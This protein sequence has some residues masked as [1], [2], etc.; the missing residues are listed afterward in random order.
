MN[1]LH[2]F[3]IFC[4]LKRVVNSV[5]SKADIINDQLIEEV[6][7]MF[8]HSFTNYW[9]M[10]FPHDELKSISGTWTDTLPELGNGVKASGYLGVA[11]TLIDS[12]DTLAVFGWRSHFRKAVRWLAKNIDFDIDVKVHLFETN[13]RLLGGLLSGHL[14]AQDSKLN[15]MPMYAGELLTL[16]ED[17]GDRMMPAFATSNNIPYAWVNLRYGISRLEKKDRQTCLAGVGSLILEFGALSYY[18]KNP[19]YFEA[20][21]LALL[22]L[23]KLRSK[24]DLL[25]NHLDGE[26]RKWVNSNAGIGAGAD[27]YYEYVLKAYITFGNKVHWNM[28]SRLYR[29]VIKHLRTEGGFFVEANMKNGNVRSTQFN[30]LQAYWPG[31]QVLHGDI[32]QATETQEAFFQLWTKFDGLPERVLINTGKA[33]GTQRHYSLRPELI[34]S[35]YHLY[36]ATKDQKFKDM[37]VTM[38]RTIQNRTRA[39]YGYAMMQNVITG[40]LAD[41]M[42]SYFLAETVKYFLLLFDNNHW[43]H[44]RISWVLSTEAHFLPIL[45]SS[46][47][48]YSPPLEIIKHPLDISKEQPTCQNWRTNEANSLI[49]NPFVPG[50]TSMVESVNHEVVWA[51]SDGRMVN[52]SV[53]PGGFTVKFQVSAESLTIRNLGRDTV[54]ILN[55]I[56]D[57][58]I[59]VA[60]V[61]KRRKL[62]LSNWVEYRGIQRNLQNET[63]DDLEDHGCSIN[64]ARRY[65]SSGAFFFE[66]TTLL[67]ELQQG[68]QVQRTMAAASLVWGGFG[69]KPEEIPHNAV[70]QIILIRRGYCTFTKKSRLAEEAGALGLIVATSNEEIFMMSD[71][72]SKRQSKIPVVMIGH[73]SFKDLRACMDVERN[74]W[75]IKV[76]IIE[77]LMSEQ[78]DDNLD[79]SEE[80][81]LDFSGTIDKIRISTLGNGFFTVTND[82]GSFILSSP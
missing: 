65:I 6:H 70:G 36:R 41:Y 23:W 74:L 51:L 32:E 49:A 77:T 14:L 37:G 50:N 34:E 31:L 35:A 52:I 39:Q 20:A 56:G 54:E 57:Q 7:E 40:E 18:T 76:A 13:I 29:A 45:Q 16:A 46:N 80:G 22:E 60:Y 53:I 42:P 55:R 81:V 47:Y 10:A 38:L 63:V 1:L 72:G 8:N 5:Q 75:H 11:L 73:E 62:F 30:A 33:H 82:N 67:R 69:C 19:V 24:L 17:L 9:E 25:G 79:A 44:S 58:E 68:E 3:L 48:T 21:D 4:V 59:F 61:D 12:L 15:L 66:P 43:V 64:L 78:D 2:L 71:D 28:F 27:S 26:K